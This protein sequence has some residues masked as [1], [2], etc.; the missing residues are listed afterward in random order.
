MIILRFFTIL[1]LLTSFLFSF[2]FKHQL[3]IR[4]FAFSH[5]R[6]VNQVLDWNFIGIL[7]FFHE[8]SCLNIIFFFIGLKLTIESFLTNMF[9]LYDLVEILLNLWG[10]DEVAYLLGF[11]FGKVV[12]VGFQL[13]V[14]IS[15]WLVL[16]RIVLWLILWTVFLL[17]I[18]FLLWNCLILLYLWLRFLLGF[19]LLISFWSSYYL[20]IF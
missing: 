1:R 20:L 11:C 12:I 6:V 3:I 17:W 5:L 8:E 16:L 14:F 15:K 18:V 10:E 13:L 19:C 2:F 4:V 7:F 9:G